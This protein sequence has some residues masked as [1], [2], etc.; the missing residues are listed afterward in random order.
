MDNA[1][2]IT[3]IQRDGFVLKE[4]ST[5]CIESW[6]D[7]C[8]KKN[9]PLFIIEDDSFIHPKFAFLSIFERFNADKIIH[10][11]VDTIINPDTPDLFTLY[12]TK[13][14]VVK[15]SGL[16]DYQISPR[17][18]K[19]VD[20]FESIFTSFNLDKSK[21]FNSGMMMFHK[22]H[23]SFLNKSKIWIENNFDKIAKWS[24][25][26]GPGLDQT[27]F[28]WLVQKNNIETNFLDMKY[29]RTGV[30]KKKLN[31]NDNYILHFRGNK[32]GLK[33]HKMKKIFNELVGL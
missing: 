27:P 11:D 29:N 4:Y 3:A 9:I 6:K 31:V 19:G 20:N 14:T 21:Y 22:N 32:H 28:N 2:V 8:T 17:M 24:I 15:D 18:S 23:K 10:V 33:V 30:F 26:G 13:F 1:I 25:N 5:F 16:I 12:D 7:W